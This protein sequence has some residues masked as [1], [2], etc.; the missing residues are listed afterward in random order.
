MTQS[1]DAVFF[2]AVKTDHQHN[3]IQMRFFLFFFLG[4]LFSSILCVKQ[5]APNK[6]WHLERIIAT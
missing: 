3:S 4:G 2:E 1:H 6:A 5:S